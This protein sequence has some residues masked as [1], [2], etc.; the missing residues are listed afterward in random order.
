MGK[1]K[2]KTKKRGKGQKKECRGD[3]A[4]SKRKMRTEKTKPI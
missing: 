2:E 3:D 1:K 4:P